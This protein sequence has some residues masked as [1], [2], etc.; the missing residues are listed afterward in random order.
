MKKILTVGM[1]LMLLIISAGCVSQPSEPSQYTDK[2]GNIF[3]GSEAEGSIHF[4]DK[5]ISKW[6]TDLEGNIRY[7]IT[8]PDGTV[9]K[10]YTNPNGEIILEI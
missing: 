8:E 3:T 1:I 7:T 5:T 10:Y 6:F 4:I 2:D 9:T